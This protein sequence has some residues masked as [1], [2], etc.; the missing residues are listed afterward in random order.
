L[1]L[2][3]ERLVVIGAV[4]E[5]QRMLALVPAGLDDPLIDRLAVEVALMRGD[6]PEVCNLADIGSERSEDGYW[7]ELVAYCD[8]AGGEI[9]RARL[10]TGL[11]RELDSQAHRDFL[12]LAELFRAEDAAKAE[13]S[14][15]M[16]TPLAVAMLDAAGA[17]F[18]AALLD[19]ASIGTLT[20]IVRHAPSPPA[21]RA[22]A[23]ERLS[24]AGASES[25]VLARLYKLLA[26]QA[27][28]ETAEVGSAAIAAALERARRVRAVSQIQNPA[29][30]VGTLSDALASFQ[31]ARLLPAAAGMLEDA[32]RAVAPVRDLAART[33]AIGRAHIHG[34]RLESAFAW[35]RVARRAARD[36]ADQAASELWPY[37]L[38]ALKGYDVSW[39]EA[40]F[41]RWARFQIGTGER[42]REE[43]IMHLL[44]IFDALGYKPDAALWE[45]LMDGPV[46]RTAL[47]PSPAIVKR[48]RSA[49]EARR[50][51]EAVLMALLTLGSVDLER[52][53]T[54]TL[55]LVLRSLMDVGLTDD[56]HAL[57]LEAITTAGY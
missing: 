50:T 39:S 49:A 53:D 20:M 12:T 52:I 7:L 11:L 28:D 42:S 48:L 2:R 44:T 30:E 54:S 21:V 15:V 51:G 38:I 46:L 9:D 31:T 26:D 34:G 10:T 36:E 43:R 14:R 32:M 47:V 45:P 8:F 40:D 41:R 16:P 13:I 37:L 25:D 5:A 6:K 19:D 56:A 29:A 1:G 57:A 22:M 33:H 35:Y 27:E 24:R 3:I 23:A 55:H 17:P 18:P 4:D